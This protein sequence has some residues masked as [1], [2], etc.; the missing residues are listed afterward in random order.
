MD[1]EDAVKKFIEKKDDI[2]LLLFDL[3]M[4][5][6]DG[7][8]A[9]KEIKR[10]NPDIPAIFISGYTKDVIQSKGIYDE[11]INLLLKPVAPDDIATKIR[12]LLIA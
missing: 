2:D 11:G 6:K 8:E 7:I 5:K 1:G 9:Y 12:E 4:P 10:I 3:V